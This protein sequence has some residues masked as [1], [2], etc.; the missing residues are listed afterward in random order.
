MA[1]GS[2]R[3]VYLIFM[4]NTFIYDICFLDIIPMVIRVWK[5]NLTFLDVHF[6]RATM[7]AL[8]CWKLQPE[9][10]FRKN[11]KSP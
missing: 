9:C 11:G 8:G 10:R 4:Q 3:K 1:V 2:L 5:T 7:L 6:S